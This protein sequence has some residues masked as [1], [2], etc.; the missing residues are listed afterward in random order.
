MGVI[1]K[2][3][4]SSTIII[5]A[6]FLPGA[7]N[8]LVLFPKFLTA[9]ELGLTRAMMDISITLS[10]LCTLG[11]LTVIYKFYPFYKDYLQEKKNDLPM[12]TAA[13]CSVGYLLMIMFGYIFRDLIV[14][15]LGKSPEFASYFYTVYIFTAFLLTFSWLEAFAWGA[16]KTVATNFLRELVVRLVTTVLLLLVGFRLISTRSFIHLFSLLYLIPAVV[17]LV[18]LV[19]SGKFRFTFTSLSSVTR[20]FKKRM[21]SFSLFVFGAQF[22]NVLARTNDTIMIIGLRGLQDTGVFAIANYFVA[23]LEIPQ[24]SINAISIPV[25]AE[26]WKNKDLKVIENIYTKSVSNLLVIG[27]GLFGLIFLNVHDVISF[28]GKDYQEIRAIVFLMGLAKV[29]DLGTGINAMIIG[30][31]NYWRFDFYTNIVYT[32]FSLPLNFIL[33]KYFGLTG[34]AIST[35]LSLSIYNLIR[36]LF[37]YKKFGFQPY[38]YKSL[39]ALFIA[40]ICYVSVYYIPQLR[41]I[42]LDATLRSGVFILLF[43][44]SMYMA[45]I[46]PDLNGTL[47]KLINDITKRRSGNQ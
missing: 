31:S 3:S 2:Q 36:Y 15:K 37:I 14:R 22:L 42:F 34:L 10:T 4:I 39:L 11:S 18:I 28:L 40:A 20:R 26:A 43:V 7:L 47:V 44:P 33:I 45:N 21:I 27:L 29:L 35:I 32:L 9:S 25:L 30:T 16:K 1:K 19:R 12:I 46:A 38:S 41:N 13:V 24:R 6:G 23:I 5:L 8:I 17:L